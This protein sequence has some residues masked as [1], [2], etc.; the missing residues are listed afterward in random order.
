MPF[1]MLLLWALTYFSEK[2]I[3]FQV[4]QH[5]IAFVILSM[6]FGIIATFHAVFPNNTFIILFTNRLRRIFNHWLIFHF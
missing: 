3:R 6:M 2:K 5:F 4:P 1:K